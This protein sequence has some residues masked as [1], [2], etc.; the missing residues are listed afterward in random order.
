MI[1]NI[2]KKLFCLRNTLK[3][4]HNGYEVISLSEHEV[5]GE[6]LWSVNVRHPSS[7]VRRQ[8]FDYITTPPTPLGQLT[9]TW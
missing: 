8:Q 1:I 9:Q 2:S 7:E 6:L 3:V 5:Q 4:T